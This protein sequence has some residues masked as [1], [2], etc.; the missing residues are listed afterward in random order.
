MLS[1]NGSQEHFELLYELEK[2][3]DYKVKDFGSVEM[4]KYQASM[5]PDKCDP[6]TE[7]IQ[8]NEELI[9]YAY[10]GHNHWAFDAS[11]LD[12]NL[13]IPS[14]ERFLE[15]GEWFL[16]RQIDRARSIPRLKTLRGWL[17]QVNQFMESLYER[18]GFV[19]TH[20]EYV[21]QIN[22]RDFEDRKFSHRI[23][24][25]EKSGIRIGS[26]SSISCGWPWRMMSQQTWLNQR[27][28]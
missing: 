11:L 15:I 9:G 27:K 18:N 24:K 16:S 13:S 8:V 4:L 1:F 28:R 6:L 23:G 14:E 2:T 21:C 17:F 5:I 10:A 26:K 20:K 3:L 25:A 22:I 7:F 19:F 12:S